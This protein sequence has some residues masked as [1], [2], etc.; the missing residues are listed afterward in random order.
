MASVFKQTYHID[1]LTISQTHLN[2]YRKYSPRIYNLI[3]SNNFEPGQNL[4]AVDFY[5]LNNQHQ[6]NLWKSSFKYHN[7]ND[8]EVQVA[9]FYTQELNS[10]Y[11]YRNVIPYF[12]TILERGKTY[13]LPIN[14]GDTI[15]L[16]IYNAEG[17]TIGKE[18]IRN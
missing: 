16:V 12:T 7:K 10:N 15:Y 14:K 17:G 3:A 13:R 18:V 1:P 2:L 11:D 5:L 8:F 9:L 4:S 6:A